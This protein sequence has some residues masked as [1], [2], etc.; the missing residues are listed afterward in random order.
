VLIR[1]GVKAPGTVL[2]RKASYHPKR[3]YSDFAKWHK[4]HLDDRGLPHS[5][6]ALASLA[7]VN[8]N[9]VKCYFYRCR[10]KAREELSSLPDLRTVPILLEDIEGLVFDSRS[11]AS[12][13]Y[14][15]DRFSQKAALQGTLKDVGEVT[16]LIPSVEMFVKRVKKALSLR[17]IK[18]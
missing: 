8:V 7:G 18:E 16:V 9:V 15:I 2:P 17:G 13:H 5:L 12:Y 3:Q 14:A 11:L 10:K 1:F 6:T 4:A